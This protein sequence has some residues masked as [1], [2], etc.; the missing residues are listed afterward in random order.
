MTRS[1][2]PMFSIRTERLDSQVCRKDPSLAIPQPMGDRQLRPSI[3]PLWKTVYLCVPPVRTMI[4]SMCDLAVSVG[5]T[6]V[7]RGYHASPVT[8]GLGE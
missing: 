7:D 4:C 5:C 6:S 3:V 8:T 1:T 2:S